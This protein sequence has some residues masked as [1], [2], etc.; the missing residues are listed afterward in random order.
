MDREGAF[1]L[2]SFIADVKKKLIAV[3]VLWICYEL[4]CCQFKKN[5]CFILSFFIKK[6]NK[7]CYELAVSVVFIEMLLLLLNKAKYFLLEQSILGVKKGWHTCEHVLFAIN[8]P[9]LSNFSCFYFI[10]RS[11]K[12]LTKQRRLQ[13]MAP[14]WNK[15]SDGS[16][17]WYIE[18]R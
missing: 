14:T 3:L 7:L 13:Q 15:R 18:L 16:D 8:F 5:L 1:N 10:R 11:F 12:W 4:V 9:F 17:I 2:H 6:I